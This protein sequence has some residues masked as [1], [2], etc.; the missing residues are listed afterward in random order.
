MENLSSLVTAATIEEFYDRSTANWLREFV[1]QNA[2]VEAA[3]RL[4]DSCVTP[5]TR[6]FLDVGCG[7][8]VSTA[9]IH[10]RYPHVFAHGVDISSRSIEA[11]RVLFGS[12]SCIFSHSDMSTIPEFSPYD[13][14][15]LVDVYEHVPRVSWPQFNKIISQCLAPGGTLVLAGP[16]PLTQ[17]W[18]AQHHPEYL[19]IVDETIECR[20]VLQLAHDVSGV[21]TMYE[22]QTIG[23][24]YDYF[25]AVIK[26][27]IQFEPVP[28]PTG[29][30]RFSAA[31][32][33]RLRRMIRARWRR[34]V[35][36]KKL[37]V[38]L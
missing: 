38:K 33:R 2:R 14:I 29:I 28:F 3:I 17:A 23:N 5:S 34:H 36:Y 20:D 4:V 6:N 22:M 37:G 27:S 8:G 35:V 25:H 11:A 24:S 12:Q 15:A 21:L 16:T 31:V 13:L 7:V 1:E 9:R 19:Q 26:R 18:F 10:A 30:V 32:L